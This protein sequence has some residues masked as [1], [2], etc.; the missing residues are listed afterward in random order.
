MSTVSRTLDQV[1]DA[2]PRPASFV[3]RVR[4]YWYVWLVVAATAIQIVALWRVLHPL[5]AASYPPLKD[6]LIFEYL[7][8]YLTE[9]GR[10]YVDVWEVKPP[11]AFELPAVLAYLAGGNVRLYH[12]LV[13]AVT[14]AAVVGCAFVVGLVTFELTDDE[15]AS[16]AAGLAL[17]ALPAFHWRAA[18]GFKA[19]YFV[20][21]FGL[22]AVYLALRDRP[23][24]AGAAAAASVGVWQLGLVF[25]GLALGVVYQRQ[26]WAGVRWTV[27]GGLLVGAIVLAPV[28]WWGAVEAMLAEVVLT[29]LL[30]SNDGGPI[31][32]QV[33]YAARLFGRTL[34]LVF[35]GAFGLL[36]GV[37]REPGARWWLAI[38]AG[39]F[40]LQVLT[41][42]LDYYPDL[43]PLFGFLALGIG[44]ALGDR[45]GT[46]AAVY[47]LV[48]AMV[49]VSVVT[50]GP[51][52]VGAPVQPPDASAVEAPYHGAE[53][54]ALLWRSI[55]TE[56][57]RPFFGA[58]QA[59]VIDLT[60]GAVGDETCGALDPLWEAFRQRVQSVV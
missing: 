35:L 28:V 60:G 30:V 14:N 45:D 16:F 25:P 1:V 17:F 6:S 10:L 38:G 39:W 51:L 47:G 7:G 41:L 58:T 27:G 40:A 19:K 37:R 46:P 42:D 3:G 21:L 29:P 11:L 13:L 55:E 57:C 23:F 32:A 48:G 52:S 54:S 9:G 26:G 50:L 53:R 24:L 20:L 22:L 8:W 49:V 34:P 31:V 59:G 36:L 15:L 33:G 5:T 44:L 2:W 12:T 56:T 18:F 43:I 4:E